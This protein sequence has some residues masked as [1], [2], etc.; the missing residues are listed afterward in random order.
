VKLIES[1]IEEGIGFEERGILW[2]D[3]VAR[4]VKI[5]L[6]YLYSPGNAANVSASWLDISIASFLFRQSTLLPT[7]YLLAT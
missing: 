3:V 7:S 1:C 6:K 2:S 5:T 4:E